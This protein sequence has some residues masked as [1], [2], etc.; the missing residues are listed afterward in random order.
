MHSLLLFIRW[1]YLF[2]LRFYFLHLMHSRYKDKHFLNHKLN[3]SITLIL[4]P[5]SRWPPQ[6]QPYTFVVQF[7]ILTDRFTAISFQQNGTS[8]VQYTSILTDAYIPFKQIALFSFFKTTPTGLQVQKLT[9]KTQ[10]TTKHPTYTGSLFSCTKMHKYTLHKKVQKYLYFSIFQ[11][12]TDIDMIIKVWDCQN[13]GMHSQG[14][15]E[16]SH[17]HNSL[18]FTE[19]RPRFYRKTKHFAVQSKVKRQHKH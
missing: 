10:E 6:K 1:D 17:L 16:I 4:L 9:P 2:F 8:H 5:I 12:M 7:H 15:C 19:V 18:A 14:P 11:I 3:S 13:V